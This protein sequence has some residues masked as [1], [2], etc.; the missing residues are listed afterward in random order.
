MSGYNLRCD[1]TF[2]SIYLNVS[3]QLRS[4]LAETTRAKKALIITKANYHPKTR[5]VVISLLD[6]FFTARYEEMKEMICLQP[7]C[8]LKE[9]N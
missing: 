6:R 8:A 3:P 5:A 1:R 9:N 7:D 2:S 4:L